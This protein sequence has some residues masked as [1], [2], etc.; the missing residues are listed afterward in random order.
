[1]NCDLSGV[2]DEATT[3]DM[4]LSFCRVAEKVYICTTSNNVR[5]T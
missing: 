5:L 3:K 4:F 1:M 2:E